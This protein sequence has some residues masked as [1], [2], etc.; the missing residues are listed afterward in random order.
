[1]L[2]SDE[3][4]EFEN[5]KKDLVKKLLEELE[6]SSEKEKYECIC[7]VLISALNNKTFYY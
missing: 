3:A 4:N 2:F 1:M 7:E 6:K 5:K